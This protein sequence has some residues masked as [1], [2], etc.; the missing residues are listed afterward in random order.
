MGKVLYFVLL[1]LLIF[2]GCLFQRDGEII[3]LGTKVTSDRLGLEPGA[4]WRYSFYSKEEVGED[5]LLLALVS[6]EEREDRTIFKLREEWGEDLGPEPLHGYYWAYDH[7]QD[8]YYEIGRW[9]KDQDFFYQGEDYLLILPSELG[10]GTKAFANYSY[11]ESFTVKGQEKVQVQDRNYWAYVLES[12]LGDERDGPFEEDRIYFVPS[13]G[14]VRRDL[15]RGFR[16]QGEI[17]EE[18]PFVMEL[19][20]YSLKD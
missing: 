19:L 12:H 5:I 14:V 17:Q 9:N 13:I 7:L 11:G 6:V 15:I 1:F 4:I 18:F 8:S 10:T 3:P 2:P 16:V 20:D